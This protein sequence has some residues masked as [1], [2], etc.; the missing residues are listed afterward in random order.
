LIVVGVL[1]AATAFFVWLDTSRQQKIKFECDH[2]R[3]DWAGYRVIYGSVRWETSAFFASN[4][5]VMAVEKGAAIL[6]YPE[7]N[8]GSND[9]LVNGYFERRFNIA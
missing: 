8:R 3:V 2:G 7:R 4:V 5:R 1:A 6:G 9:T